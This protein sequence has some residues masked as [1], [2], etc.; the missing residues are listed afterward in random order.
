[1]VYLQT[2][3]PNLSKFL[4]GVGMENV[5]LFYDL[6]VHFTAI[7]YIVW[8]IGIFSRYL[9]Y[10]YHFGILFQEK[11]GNPASYIVFLSPIKPK[12]AVP[13]LEAVTD[14][15]FYYYVRVTT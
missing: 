9:V 6:L 11:S 3:S 10:F 4:E 5:G 15:P 13:W 8:A 7:W 1:M 12:S 2:K 14:V